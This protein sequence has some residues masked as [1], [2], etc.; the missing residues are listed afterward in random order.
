[1]ELTFVG[2]GAAD[3][4]WA[5]MPP[6]TRGSTATLVN[7]ACLVDAGPTVFN[8]LGR[9]GVAP[10]Q[11]SDVVVTHS[12]YDHFV[13]ET[14]AAIAS[15]RGDGLMVWASP[16]ALAKLDG[17]NCVRREIHPGMKF[18]CAGLEFTALPSNHSTADAEE[19][20]MHYFVEDGGAT[21]LYALD[22]A[23][24]LA[25][26]RHILAA[27]LHGRALDA[28]VWDA[29]CG[30]TLHD[31][32][33]SEHNDLAMIEALRAAM[34]SVG[35]VSESTAHIFDHVACG[36]W[37]ETAEGRAALAAKYGGILAEDGQKLDV[38]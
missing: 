21:L 23:W 20:T 17:V 13:P 36:L 2:T 30:E 38:H 3:W 10:A 6:G 15:S 4:D 11:I 28:V 24:M 34:L 12:H 26:A 32:R 16:Q 25:K 31:R 18:V 7:G 9:C 35:L 22:G 27:A 29:T 14:V 5:N 1:M 37:P 19:E 8:A 33:F